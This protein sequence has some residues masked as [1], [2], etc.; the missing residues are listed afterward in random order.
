MILGLGFSCWVCGLWCFDACVCGVWF[1]IVV[2]GLILCLWL[3]ACD[4]GFDACV[5]CVTLAF[6]FDVW[7]LVLVVDCWFVVLVACRRFEFCVSPLSYF[8]V[9]LYGLKS[10]LFGM[11]VVWFRVRMLWLEWCSELCVMPLGFGFWHGA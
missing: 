2:S 11:H 5:W 9:W 4:F 7:R 6:G 1:L 8:L 3:R 10:D